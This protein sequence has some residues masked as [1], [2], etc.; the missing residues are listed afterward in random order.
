MLT[1]KQRAY[2]RS[3]SNTMDT[4]LIIG[5]GGIN[6]EV[7]NQAIDALKARELIKV[8]VLETSKDGVDKTAKDLAGQTKAEL[9]CVIGSKF[10]LYKRNYQ[11]TRII[12]SENSKG[13]KVVSPV[14]VKKSN[15]KS[16]VK[17]QSNSRKSYSRQ[18]SRSK[19]RK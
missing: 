7:I 18:S 11:D 17:D 16:Y 10:I 2:L 5:K 19:K 12:L 6:D 8:K 13:F 14:K 3:I 4:I 15:K 1:S 9:V